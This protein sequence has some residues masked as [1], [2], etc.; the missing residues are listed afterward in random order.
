MQRLLI[1]G[2]SGGGKST[3]SRKLSEKLALPLTH[4]DVLFWKPGWTESTYDEFRPKI[5]AVTATDRWI[6]D[7][8]FSATFDI[9]M[10]RA[11]TIIWIDQPRS[12]C[13]G[14][15]LRRAVTQLGRTREDVAPGCPERLDLEFSAMCGRSRLR[16]TRRSLLRSRRIAATQDSSVCGATM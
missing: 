6:I 2:C 1:I 12:L 4:L 8:N 7:G 5:A 15:V 13:M 16:M 3:L 10:P 14:R 11:D 9:R